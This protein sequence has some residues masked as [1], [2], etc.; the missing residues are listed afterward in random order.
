MKDAKGHGSS[1]KGVYA[2][3]Q[4]GVA[5]ATASTSEE[6]IQAGGKLP[7]EAQ[8]TDLISK[9]SSWIAGWQSAPL[10]DAG[11]AAVGR[12]QDEIDRANANKTKFGTEEKPTAYTMKLRSGK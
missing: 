11:K 10:T 7:T 3:H 2:A 6:Y 12:L 8:H 5:Q 9:N 4:T 1:S